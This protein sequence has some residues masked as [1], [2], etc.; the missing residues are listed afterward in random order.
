VRRR[1]E[2][3]ETKCQ[4]ERITATA[5]AIATAIAEELWGKGIPPYGGK[6]ARTTDE[7]KME[8]P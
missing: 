6:P 1:K 4:E 2:R 7:E 3:K 5:T 8:L